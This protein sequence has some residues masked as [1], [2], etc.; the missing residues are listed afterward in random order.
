MH[1]FLWMSGALF[2][3]CLMAVGAR[4]LSGEIAIVETQFFRSVIGL[5]CI[6][7]ILR[8]RKTNTKT[9]IRTARIR[10]HVFRN[11]FHF[12][13]QYCW[14]F[15]L[16]LLPLAEVFALEFT[17]P[18]WTIIIASVFL[19]EKITAR[20]LLAI[21]L[22]ML[23]VFIIVQPGIAIVDPAS[24]I[25][26][27]AAIFFAISY[28]VTKSLTATEDPLSIL[29]YMCLLQLPAGLLLSLGSWVWPSGLEWCWLVVIGLTALSAHYCMAKAMQYAEVST[30]VTLDFLRLP[31]IGLVGILLYR[32]AFELALIFGGG[33]ML[34][35]NLV[36]MYPLS[37]FV[38]TCRN[39]ISRRF[40]SN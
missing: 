6:L 28:S 13:G 17:V 7:C 40:K 26:L 1:A 36:S 37:R 8:L 31:L 16:G 3:F 34:L 15:G 38:T 18:I 20:K 4:E 10:L 24:L 35:A 32:E 19:N 9:L 27:A 23:G 22:G 39:L 2:S 25:V 5:L 14:F 29:F 12:A 21:F 11:I 33:L 30:I